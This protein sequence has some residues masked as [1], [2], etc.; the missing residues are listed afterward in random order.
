MALILLALL[1][2]FTEGVRW[3]A[4]RGTSAGARPLRFVAATLTYALPCAALL[5]ADR[6]D[7]S[8]LV[9]ALAALSALLGLTLERRLY[10]RSLGALPA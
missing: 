5:V 4:L 1:L 7:G 3:Q 2:G 8:V 6:R 9:V 10:V